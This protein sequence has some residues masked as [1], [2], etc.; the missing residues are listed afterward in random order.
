MNHDQ[1]CDRGSNTTMDTT[2]QVATVLHFLKVPVPIR[3]AFD[4]IV[5]LLQFDFYPLA[6]K[7]SSLLPMSSNNGRRL[8]SSSSGSGSYL[9]AELPNN[10]SFV[11]D[12]TNS[13]LAQQ[14]YYRALA[15]DSAEQL[16]VTKLP[17][18]IQGRLADLGQPRR[19]CSAGA[20]LGFRLQ[21][22]EH[23][24][25]RADFHRWDTFNGGSRRSDQRLPICWLLIQELHSSRQHDELCRPGLY[26]R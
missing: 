21:P 14:L 9:T 18:A 5:G 2:W 7:S 17:S 24:R 15:G 11:F 25:V 10:D 20:F 3:S 23:Q 1:F 8:A 16:N 4:L 22:V 12:G 13:D 6:P 26:W 19:P